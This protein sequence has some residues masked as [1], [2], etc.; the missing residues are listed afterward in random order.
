[1]NPKADSSMKISTWTVQVLLQRTSAFT[2]TS[3]IQPSHIPIVC[4]HAIINQSL[5]W[6]HGT[7]QLRTPSRQ[8]YAFFELHSE[9]KFEIYVWKLDMQV[10][11]AGMYDYNC[12]IYHIIE[13][14]GKMTTWENI[15]APHN[16]GSPLWSQ[17]LKWL[18]RGKKTTN[19]LRAAFK[20]EALW[21]ITCKCCC[22]VTCRHSLISSTERMSV[23]CLVTANSISGELLS[24]SSAH[25]KNRIPNTEIPL[26]MGTFLSSPHHTSTFISSC[27]CC[28]THS[29]EN[30]VRLLSPKQ[31]NT[32]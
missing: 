2:S 10:E 13:D 16:H 26:P 22:R 25:A 18:W 8:C 11:T 19:R 12:H 28:H 30:L 6:F 3:S 23:F 32:I 4:E 1:M 14:N 31:G 27:V 29:V 24:V 21:F 17:L 5:I 7:L 20:L 9:D 15:G